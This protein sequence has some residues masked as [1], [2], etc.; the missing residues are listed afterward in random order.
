MAVAFSAGRSRECSG[1]VQAEGVGPPSPYTPS[2]DF[3][4]ATESL[5][6]LRAALSKLSSDMRTVDG[7]LTLRL[8]PKPMPRSL[9]LESQLQEKEADAS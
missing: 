9:S 8:R 3:P 6:R 5:R 1:A 7:L 2:S 4:H